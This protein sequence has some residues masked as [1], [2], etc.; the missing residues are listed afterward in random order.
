MLKI[1]S[2]VKKVEIRGVEIRKNN[3]LHLE[4]IQYLL[5]NPRGG[6]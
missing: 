4:L 2:F 6:F 3:S 1:A 5:L